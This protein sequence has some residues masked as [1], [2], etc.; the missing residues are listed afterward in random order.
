MCNPATRRT[1]VWAC[2]LQVRVRRSVL[3][4]PP[5]APHTGPWPRASSHYPEEDTHRRSYWRL[6]TD[7]S[8]TMAL[9]MSA[10]AMPCFLHLPPP[11]GSG[12]RG[13]ADYDL[14]KQRVHMESKLL[15]LYQFPSYLSAVASRS[16]RVPTFFC[17]R[18]ILHYPRGENHYHTPLSLFFPENPPEASSISSPKPYSGR[19]RPRRTLSK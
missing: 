19:C 2:M 7:V 15:P 3:R 17:F 9:A 11:A 10:T 4:A 13:C 12:E 14:K 6:T 18:W 16:S 1:T 8:M 5:P